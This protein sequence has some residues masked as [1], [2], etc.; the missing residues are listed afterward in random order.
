MLRDKILLLGQRIVEKGFWFFA[1]F[2]FFY[3]LGVWGRNLCYDLGFLRVTKVRPVV[4]S[5]GNITCG[6][7]GK[8]PLVQLLAERF[9]DRKVAVLTRGYGKIADEAMLH[10][11][12]G[13]QVYIGKNRA[14]L[15]KKIDADLIILDD[16]FQHRKLSRDFD[17]VLIRRQKMHY[18]PWGFLRDSP[19]RLKRADLTLALGEEIDLI[20]KRIVDLKGNVIES[21]RGLSVALFCGIANPKKFKK[22]VEDLGAKVESMT[23]FADHGIPDLAK[24]PQAKVYICTEKDFVKLPKTELPIYYL[25][26]QMQILSRLADWEMLVEKIGQKIDNRPTL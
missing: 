15:A 13:L 12:K 5:I 25:E 11:R 14:K 6:G 3:A 7:T 19:R 20:L 21:I 4:V 24:L 9:Q 10:Q 1:P 26:M 16:G 23:I 22:T 18:L 8:T 2:S 17:I